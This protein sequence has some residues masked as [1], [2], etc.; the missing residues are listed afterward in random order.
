MWFLNDTLVTTPDGGLK[1][2][3]VTFLT[4][5]LYAISRM[6]EKWINKKKEEVHKENEK[7]K[8]DSMVQLA[9]DVAAMKAELKTN[10]GSSLK[11]VVIKT[12]DKMLVIEKQ[13]ESVI[14]QARGRTELALDQSDVAQFLANEKGEITFAND[15][16]ADLFGLGKNHLL[17]N[18]W[19]VAIDHQSQRR[20]L[21]ERLSFALQRNFTFKMDIDI[22]CQREPYKTTNV[23]LTVEPTLD[24]LGNFMWN[25]GRFKKLKNG[26]P[27]IDLNDELEKTE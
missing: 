22:K 19:L 20:S 10:G 24:A 12:H 2:A 27:R 9:S 15:A 7:A 8:V 3:F 25:K 4:I 26:T 11:D 13:V 5:A 6:I 16:M 17:N 18:K 1:A 23:R 21:V 14:A